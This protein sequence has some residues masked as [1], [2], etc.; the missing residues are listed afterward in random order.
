MMIGMTSAGSLNSVT[1]CGGRDIVE[2]A[3]GTRGGNGTAIATP[4]H[5]AQVYATRTRDMLP[6]GHGEYYRTLWLF[7]DR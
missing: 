5:L 4:A 7:N 1:L 3:G 6:V 2:S